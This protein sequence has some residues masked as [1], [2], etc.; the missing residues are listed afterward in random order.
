MVEAIDNAGAGSGGDAG[1][2]GEGT[3]SLEEQL[4]NSIPKD[5][6]G[7]PKLGDEGAPAADPAKAVETGAAASGQPVPLFDINGKMSL[8]A[9]DKISPDHVKELER[10]WLREADYTRKTQDLAKTRAAAQDV[11]KAQEEVKADPRNLFKF[12]QPQDVLSAFTR[13]EMLSH[14]LHAGGV[15]PQVWNQFLEWHKENGEAGAGEAPPKADPYSQQFGEFSRRIEAMERQGTTL[16][17]QRKAD[18]E[19]TAYNEQMSTYDKEVEGALKDFPAVNKR[20]LLVEMA[21]SD[22]TKTVKELAQDLNVVLETRFQEYLKTKQG[23]RQQTVKSAKGSAVPVL[24]QKPKTFEEADEQIAK[25]Y[26]E[27]SLRGSEPFGS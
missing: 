21:A 22:G 20:Q 26:G 19:A 13:Q 4:L 6:E 17:E 9:G 15:S 12:M 10:G 2:F 27:G 8:K 18:T 3:G 14:G 5:G 25:M 24:K 11:L 7:E 16:A 23:Q 1:D